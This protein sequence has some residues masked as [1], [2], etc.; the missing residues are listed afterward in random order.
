MGLD[1]L[2]ATIAQRSGRRDL[3]VAVVHVRD[4]PASWHGYQWLYTHDTGIRAHRFNNYGEWQTLHCPFGVIGLEYTVPTGETFD[5]AA[6][7]LKDMSILLPGGAVDFLGSEVATDA[8]SNFDACAD[9]LGLLDAALRRFGN[10][11]ISTGRQGAGIYINLD[12]AMRL[13][14]RVAG[15]CAEH[16]GVVGR[17]EYSPYQE[18]VS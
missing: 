15:L 10:G 4:C 1:E 13:G 14:K 18:K 11:V 6:T 8:Y 12:Q 2:G 3:I 5:V 9:H 17:D 16:S 7:A